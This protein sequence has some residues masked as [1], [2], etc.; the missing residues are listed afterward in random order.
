MLNFYKKI[1]FSH[2]VSYVWWPEWAA[3][4]ESIRP[5]SREDTQD[6]Q[7]MRAQIENLWADWVIDQ[8]DIQT[9]LS[10]MEADRE[11]LTEY[12][13]QWE[14]SLIINMLR[15]MWAQLAQA[16]TDINLKTREQ[17]RWDDIHTVSVDRNDGIFIDTKFDALWN[18]A[19]QWLIAKAGLTPEEVRAAIASGNDEQNLQDASSAAHQEYAES[20]IQSDTDIRE[21]LAAADLAK[22]LSDEDAMMNSDLWSVPWENYKAMMAN[23]DRADRLEDEDAA[24]SWTLNI[25]NEIDYDWNKEELLMSQWFDTNT[26]ANDI[27]SAALETQR[28]NLISGI[29]EDAELMF[30]ELDADEMRPLSDNEIQ[31]ALDIRNAF[32]VTPTQIQN[33]GL[34]MDDVAQIYNAAMSKRIAQIGV[35][36]EETLMAQAIDTG[37][38]QRDIDANAEEAVMAQA[39]DT[40]TAQRDI[41][42]NAEETVMAQS[43]ESSLDSEAYPMLLSAL[44]DWDGQVRFSEIQNNEEASSAIQQALIN[45]FGIERIQTILG[46]SDMTEEKFSDGVYGGWTSKVVWEYQTAMGLSVDWEAGTQTIASLTGLD[47][48]STTRMASLPAQ[49][50]TWVMMAQNTRAAREEEAV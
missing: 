3:P 40:S 21:E 37:T 5:V 8:A 38:A 14:K 9:V 23:F 6:L 4:T 17:R 35:E 47:Y 29:E 30:W 45:H 7:E 32:G 19:I 24:M 2:F 50:D 42:T 44:Q 25:G 1:L 31:R 34:E 11:Q 28:D 36:S 12:T 18:D 43:L 13:R 15:D 27:A 16:W 10:D 48:D 20:R 49:V 26:A 46:R 41:D 33:A 22:R 39:I